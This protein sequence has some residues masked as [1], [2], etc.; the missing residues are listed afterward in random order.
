MKTKKNYIILLLAMCPLLSFAQYTFNVSTGFV[1][2]N[3]A[4]F[5]KKFNDKGVL[6]A[7]MQYVNAKMSSENANFSDIQKVSLLVPNIGYKHYVKHKEKLGAYLQLNFTKPFLTGK[8]ETD[9]V[10]DQTFKESIQ[11]IKMWG[12][13][14]SYGVEYA[15]D[16]SFSIGGEFGIRHGKYS[17]KDDVSGFEE[18]ISIN[19]TFSRIVL[20]YYF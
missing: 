7:G 12:Y 3:A 6:F 11:N 5:G 15:F 17:N 1:G 16:P 19:P 10:E 8:S 14:L 20:N 18:K 2:F 4:S 13:E 9:G